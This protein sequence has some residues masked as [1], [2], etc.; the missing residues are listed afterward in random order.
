MKI[1]LKYLFE[2]EYFDG[3]IYKQ[4]EQDHSIKFPPVKDENGEYQGKSCMSDIQED[5]DN[6]KIKKFTLKEQVLLGKKISVD[7]TDGHFKIDG[8]LIEVE[9][10]KPLPIANPEFK[11]IFFRVRR[12][13]LT[14]HLK[15]DTGQVTGV[16]SGE[17]TPKYMIGWQTTIAGKN[18]IQKILVQ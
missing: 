5:V 7:L 15:L 10:E 6:F 11:L 12:P 3:S 9:G 14:T 1:K 18:Y 17:F 13:Y 16:E 4:N 8:V 2:A